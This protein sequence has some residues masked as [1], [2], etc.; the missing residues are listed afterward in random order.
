M[1]D[2]DSVESTE[3]S[4]D[5]EQLS[6]V[7]SRI[8]GLME[9]LGVRQAELGRM[10]KEQGAW[11]SRPD[12][13]VARWLRDGQAPT[14]FLTLIRVANALNTST[15]Y[16][17]GLKNDSDGDPSMRS[18]SE[19]PDDLHEL[20]HFTRRLARSFVDADPI[21]GLD[22]RSEPNRAWCLHRLLMGLV[23]N[24]TVSAD[25]LLRDVPEGSDSREMRQARLRTLM[26]Y[27]S[28]HIRPHGV[29]HSLDP[30]GGWYRMSLRQHR[31]YTLFPL[32]WI[33]T[34]LVLALS[35]LLWSL[36]SGLSGADLRIILF[37][38]ASLAPVAFGLF[39]R[40]VRSYR[41]HGAGRGRVFA[42]LFASGVIAWGGSHF[43][44][45]WLA[46]RWFEFSSDG[47]LFLFGT[48]LVVGYSTVTSQ[49]CLLFLRRSGVRSCI[50]EAE[51]E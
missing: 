42:S 47:P 44:G 34:A 6:R 12:E 5:A 19:M 38:V 33:S 27:T 9:T 21:A 20:K 48:A 43:I 51:N 28:A 24:Q 1:D 32:A 36:S 4:R 22:L 2:G 26:D 3:Q 41:L 18:M 39:V 49:I 15:D 50:F 46:G 7:S 31:L 29:E 30:E 45:S 10:L 40:A 8:S 14:N 13:G 23:C 35:T 37:G 16:L 11:S 25:D 17:L